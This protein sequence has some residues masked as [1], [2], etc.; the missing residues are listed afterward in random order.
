MSERVFCCRQVW[1]T[2][3]TCARRRCSC[4]ASTS[5][6]ST[7][8]IAGCLSSACARSARCGSNSIG[9]AACTARVPN[10]KLVHGH[11]KHL[12][13]VGHGGRQHLGNGRPCRVATQTRVIGSDEELTCTMPTLPGTCGRLPI[14]RPQRRRLQG[15]SPPGVTDAP[16]DVLRRSSARRRLWAE[17]HPAPSSWLGAVQGERPISWTATIGRQVAAVCSCDR[18]STAVAINGF[19]SNLGPLHWLNHTKAMSVRTW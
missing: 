16:R 12:P 5:S 15:A 17:P 18:M 4:T 11:A 14:R 2:S 19:S 6:A 3:W 9:T 10:S 13:S 7:A 1:A 8:L